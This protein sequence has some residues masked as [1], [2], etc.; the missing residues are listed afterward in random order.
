M[1][2]KVS[3]DATAIPARPAGGG[4]YVLELARALGQRDDVD[5]TVVARRGDGARWRTLPGVNVVEQASSSR[6]MRLAWEQ[7]GLPGLLGRLGVDVHHAPH[8][9]MPRRA[10]LPQVVTVHD[11]T[12][13]DHPEWH[14]G[15][16]V[17][18]F[19]HATRIAAKRAHALVCVSAL[20][21][22]RLQDLLAPAAP[23]VVITHGVDH[24]RFR[25]GGE[26]N[27]DAEALAAIGVRAPY[28]AF[29][30]TLEPRKDVPTLVGAFDR[31]ADARPD[32]TLVLGGIDGWGAKAVA[33][34]IADARHGD[35]VARLGYVADDAVPALLRSAAAVAYPSL[36]EGFGLPA[37]EALACGAPLVT[38]E[39]TAMAE[40]TGDAAVLVAP[41]DTA[42]LADA[43]DSLVE[44]G[45]DVDRRRQ[46]G[47]AVA[48]SYTWEASAAAHAD[49]YRSVLMS[50]LR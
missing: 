21:A 10:R 5:L 18:F 45:S 42:A 50:P 32:L 41:G 12:F 43:L 15:V 35:R 17:R 13:F 46:R 48:A 33:E 3:L 36:D 27:A 37:L 49:V 28:V 39:G 2:P 26:G 1:T 30:G 14:E 4:R 11:L 6:P 31:V 19:R 8:Y 20:T 44:G 22:A 34:A 24:T 40:V 25:P 47:V 16:K 9:T 23:V 7:L 38:T 29:V